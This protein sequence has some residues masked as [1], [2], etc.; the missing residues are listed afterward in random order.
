M[1]RGNL[2]SRFG[3]T[4]V[5]VNHVVSNGQALF[6]RRLRCQ[7]TARL[8][9]GF[10]VASQQAL[11]LR[12]FAAVHDKYSV[13]KRLQRRTDEQWYHDELIRAV[14]LVCLT[15]GFGLY[16]GVQDSLEALPRLVVGKNQLAH[17]RTVQGAVSID[18]RV[19]ERGNDVGECRL[20]G[21]YDLARN[22]VGI[23]DSGAELGEH[24]GDG[25]LP[26]GN[27]AG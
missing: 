23:D 7:D 6:P 12:V 11:D 9:L 15:P 20:A 22:D 16:A 26:A 5:V 24:V 25:R 4:L 18:D 17:G 1:K 19:T 2:A 3:D 21:L 13:D 10:R 8:L 27:A 14:G